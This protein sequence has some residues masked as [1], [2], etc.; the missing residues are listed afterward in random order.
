ME[1]NLSQV[2]KGYI[3]AALFSCVDDGE[4]LDADYAFDD[5][6]NSAIKTAENIC[7]KFVDSNKESILKYMEITGRSSDYVGH[8]LLLNQNGHGVG[9]WDRGAGATGDLL[10]KS[11]DALGQF[12]LYI[13]DDGELYT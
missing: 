4:Y 10:S 9:F 8:D 7:G 12:D 3:D 2:V 13:G 11:C 1:I 5:V 6:H